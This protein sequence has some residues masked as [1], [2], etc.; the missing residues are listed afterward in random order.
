VSRDGDRVSEHIGIVCQEMS[1]DIYMT[2]T[3]NPGFHVALRRLPTG[4]IGS[5]LFC[6][7]ISGR[8]RDGQEDGTDAFLSVLTGS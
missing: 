3:G 1:L 7:G 8:A 6:H 5:A 4:R 2:G